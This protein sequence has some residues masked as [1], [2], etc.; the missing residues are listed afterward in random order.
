MPSPETIDQGIFNKNNYKQSQNNSCN[1]FQIDPVS[2]NSKTHFSMGFGA[3]GKV[4][5]FAIKDSANTAGIIDACK[6]WAGEN[7]CLNANRLF[8]IFK[9]M[10]DVRIAI[11]TCELNLRK[12][13][14]KD[15]NQ[16][17]EDRIRHGM[18]KPPKTAKINHYQK[19][20]SRRIFIQLLIIAKQL[21]QNSQSKR[22]Q[23]C[24]F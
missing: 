12:N 22:W 3:N 15:S 6:K 5:K 21:Q 11:A 23:N 24:R 2:E 14:E 9:H 19:I 18:P 1:Y 20:I 4:T 7:N 16:P 13:I 17:M 8:D 10:D